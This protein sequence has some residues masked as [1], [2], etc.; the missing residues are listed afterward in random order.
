ML[1][2]ARIVT[3]MGLAH[4][5]VGFWALREQCGFGVAGP[6]VGFLRLPLRYASLTGIKQ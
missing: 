6:V 4:Y 2:G 3:D 5:A 1:C